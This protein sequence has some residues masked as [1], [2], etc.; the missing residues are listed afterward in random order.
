MEEIKPRPFDT[1]QLEEIKNRYYEKC[2]ISI[3]IKEDETFIMILINDSG[4]YEIHNK[5][6]TDVDLMIII[7]QFFNM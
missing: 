1:S 2:E 3:S 6:G 4:K 5:F 7:N